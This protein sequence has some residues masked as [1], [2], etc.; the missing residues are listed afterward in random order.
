MF[1]EIDRLRN[2]GLLVQLLRH[3]AE[4]GQDHRDVWQDRFPCDGDA[5]NRNHIN[6]PRF[7]REA[8][9]KSRNRSRRNELLTKPV[10]WM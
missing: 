6:S 1:D 8:V 9:S 3:Y 2:N 10:S 5:G 4:L 7:P